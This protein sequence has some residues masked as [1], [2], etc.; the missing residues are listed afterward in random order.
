MSVP[1]VSSMR[2]TLARRVARP[3]AVAAAMVFAAS[4]AMADPI[5]ASTTAAVGSIDPV[6]KVAAEHGGYNDGKARFD[7]ILANVPFGDAWAWRTEGP[8]TMLANNASGINGGMGNYIYFVFRQT[9]DLTGYDPA[10]ADLKFRWASDDVPGAVGWMPALSLNGGA[11]QKAGT[12]GAYTLGGV[13]ELNSGF[14]AGL[15]T[16]DFYVEG[17]GQTDGFA[18]SR[19]SF[20]AGVV[21]EPASLLLMACGLGGVMAA[22]RRRRG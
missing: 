18:L 14:V 12:S 7:D 9:F 15:N 3:V 16:L 5:F 19:E 8:V 22:V 20:T 2:P 13:V 17:N 21:P 1:A 4:A 11:L 10:T 6:W